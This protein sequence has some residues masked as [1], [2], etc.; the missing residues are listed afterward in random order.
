MLKIHFAIK[1]FLENQNLP[2]V[3]KTQEL[4]NRYKGR[5][6]WKREY[7]FLTRFNMFSTVELHFGAT[8]ELRPPQNKDHFPAASKL[9]LQC[10]VVSE[11][12]PP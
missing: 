7:S 8:S 9:Y 1:I 12:R 6:G 2:M 3:D 11:M 5:I 4:Q 10:S